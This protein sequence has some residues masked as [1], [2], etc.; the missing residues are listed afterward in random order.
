MK[1]AKIANAIGVASAIASN[2]VLIAL[3]SVFIIN[4]RR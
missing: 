4:V 3:D 1:S 2:A